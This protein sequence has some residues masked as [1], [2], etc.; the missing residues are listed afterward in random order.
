MNVLFLRLASLVSYPTIV[1]SH[2]LTWRITNY[3][4][5]TICTGVFAEIIFR[6]EPSNI[7]VFNGEFGYFPCVYE[8]T[9]FL[10]SWVIDDRPYGS[11][12]LPPQYMY[13][14]S[15]LIV[16]ASVELNG[17]SVSCF[18]TQHE[19]RIES[20]VAHLTVVNQVEG[21]KFVNVTL[22]FTRIL[23]IHEQAQ[24]WCPLF[25]Q[26]KKNTG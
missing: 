15:G 1:I 4:Y 9:N 24:W 10:P 14:W 25:T 20:R 22:C 6:K 19:T 23:F 12:N 18:F 17:S 5:I 2:A 16:H 3:S 8:G 7:T 26:V 11:T 13:N 21:E